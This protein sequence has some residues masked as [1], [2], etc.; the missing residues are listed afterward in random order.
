MNENRSFSRLS[1]EMTVNLSELSYPVE[2]ERESTVRSKDIGGGGICL[3]TREQF[4]P[5]TLVNLKIKIENLEGYKRPFSM[6]LDK[7]NSSPLTAVAEVIWSNEY[8]EEF[9]YL[10]GIKF[11]DIYEDDYRGLMEFLTVN[12]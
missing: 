11:L 3:K 12:A 10:T 1:K 6:F 7:S 2:N 9:E 5:R 4:E 8:S